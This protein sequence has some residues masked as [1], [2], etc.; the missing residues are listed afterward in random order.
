MIDY[1]CPKCGGSMSSPDSLSGRSDTCPACGNIC[2]IPERR[3]IV[4]ISRVYDKVGATAKRIGGFCSRRRKL[5]AI[6]GVNLILLTGFLSWFLPDWLPRP[7]VTF[8]TPS[9]VRAKAK[10]GLFPPRAELAKMLEEHRYYLGLPE[11]LS[12]VLR[13]RHLWKYMYVKDVNNPSWAYIGVW[14]P[15]DEKDKVIAVTTEIVSGNMAKVAGGLNGPDCEAAAFAH[16]RDGPAFIKAMSSI[17]FT[18]DK[19]D[20][21]GASMR[22]VGNKKIVEVSLYGKGFALE[23]ISEYIAVNDEFM[24]VTF[25][26]KDKNWK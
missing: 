4:W 14:C 19:Q 18:S 11:P 6:V 1:K 17:S 15:L 21:K 9:K 12:G 16:I 26:L 20:F 13:G 22:R 25:I 3:S 7:V 8:E 10:E 24:M 23:V 2:N 5:V